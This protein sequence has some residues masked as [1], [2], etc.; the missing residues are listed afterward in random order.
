MT[1]GT[2][3]SFC[4]PG[5]LYYKSTRSQPQRLCRLSVVFNMLYCGTFCTASTSNPFL[6]NPQLSGQSSSTQG[7][8]GNSKLGLRGKAHP[9]GQQAWLRLRTAM[10]WHHW[11]WDGVVGCLWCSV[12]VIWLPLSPTMANRC[13]ISSLMSESIQHPY[14]LYISEYQFLNSPGSQYK[15]SIS[16]LKVYARV[17]T[18]MKLINTN[19]LSDCDFCL[20]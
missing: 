4:R 14:Q 10:E 8:S 13:G 19:K 5:L 3:P 12:V 1:Q 9:T 2:K 6:S 7:T 11:K 18:A 17:N 16:N 20:K 15:F